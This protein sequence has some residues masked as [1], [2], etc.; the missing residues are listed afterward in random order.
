MIE[1]QIFD[2]DG[3]AIA[4]F[5]VF[6]VHVTSEST[7]INAPVEDGQPSFDNIV[8]QPK[9]IVVNG[10]IEKSANTEEEAESDC[11]TKI[12]ELQASRDF[13]FL[14]VCD[15]DITFNN[16]RL[17]TIRKTRSSGTPDFLEYELIYEEVLLVSSDG[18][19]PSN[20]ENTNTRSNGNASAA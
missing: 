11:E 2:F 12:Y 15:G 10:I 6:D 5:N 20:P 14:S 1:A 19:S 18:G 8:Q 9:Q 16:L 3:N 17:K 4:G 7:L 13:K